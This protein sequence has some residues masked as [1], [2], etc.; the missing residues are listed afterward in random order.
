MQDMMT[1]II[2]EQFN[3]IDCFQVYQFFKLTLSSWSHAE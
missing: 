2:I 3:G 1:L